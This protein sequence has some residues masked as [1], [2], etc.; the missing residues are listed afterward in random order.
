[1]QASI[2]GLYKKFKNKISKNDVI[3]IP[4]YN[5][6]HKDTDKLR[7]LYNEVPSPNDLQARIDKSRDMNDAVS[8]IDKLFDRIKKNKDWKDCER[9]QKCIDLWNKLI[10]KHKLHDKSSELSNVSG[11]SKRFKDFF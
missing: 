7:A 5:D 10:D 6:T 1:M 9:A 3:Y 8:K 11:G 2:T 4:D